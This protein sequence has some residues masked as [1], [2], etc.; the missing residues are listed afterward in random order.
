M[1]NLQ[2]KQLPYQTEAVEAVV[3]CFA[4]QPKLSASSYRIDPGKEIDVSG[5][6]RTDILQDGFKNND[7]MLKPPQILTNVQD[8]ADATFELFQRPWHGSPTFTYSLGWFRSGAKMKWV[9][10]DGTSG[11]TTELGAARGATNH[12]CNQISGRS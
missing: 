11:G 1:K 9:V 3:D 2:F 8:V 7:L 5:Q 4:G 6:R 12:R 10:E